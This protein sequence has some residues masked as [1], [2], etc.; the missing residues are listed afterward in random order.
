M[1]QTAR[2]LVYTVTGIHLGPAMTVTGKPYEAH[3]TRCFGWYPTLDEALKAAGSNAADINEAGHYPWL[4][5]EAVGAGVYGGAMSDE[6]HWFRWEQ[7]GLY[8]GEGHY[9]ACEP[10][11]GIAM[12]GG[13]RFVGFGM[14]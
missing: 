3:D 11:E 4:V 2:E 10:P 14:G 7:E 5:V 13:M 12:E 8:A 6:Q 1:A 9:E